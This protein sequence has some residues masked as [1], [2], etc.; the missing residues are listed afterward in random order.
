MDDSEPTKRAD[1]WG[2]IRAHERDYEAECASVSVAELRSRLWN[3]QR[4]LVMPANNSA[5]VTNQLRTVRMELSRRKELDVEKCRNPECT[6]QAPLR[7]GKPAYR[8]LC[9]TCGKDKAIRDRYGLPPRRSG[10][11]KPR[12]R[13]ETTEAARSVVIKSP[14]KPEPAK[15]PV[16]G[17][18]VANGAKG[19]HVHVDLSEN[20]LVLD[21]RLVAGGQTNG[22][23]NGS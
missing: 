3:L 19:G 6:R 8:G 7:N 4:A 13:L 18:L 2:P 14:K 15:P 10:P 1:P 5:V 12:K 9:A 11:S 21:I 20:R 16:A 22:G 17:P 23:D